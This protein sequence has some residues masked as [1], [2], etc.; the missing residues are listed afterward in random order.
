MLRGVARAIGRPDG[1][2]PAAAQPSARWGSAMAVLVAA[3][4]PASKPAELRDGRHS[5]TDALIQA[6]TASAL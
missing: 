2:A 1:R 6:H 4:P 3:V 5:I